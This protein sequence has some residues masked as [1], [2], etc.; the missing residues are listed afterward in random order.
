MAEGEKRPVVN[1]GRVYTRGAYIPVDWPSIASYRARARGKLDPSR[2]R[3]VINLT[4]YKA[5]LTARSNTYDS[6]SR[7]CT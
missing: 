4:S 1:T 7:V 6:R 5:T 2:A 3:N